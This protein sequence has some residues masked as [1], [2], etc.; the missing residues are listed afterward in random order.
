[1]DIQEKEEYIIEADA[2]SSVPG[3]KLKDDWLESLVYEYVANGGTIQHV[4]PGVISEN[5]DPPS[6]NYARLSRDRQTR[7]KRWDEEKVEIIRISSGVRARR[8][9]AD[10]S[11]ATPSS[12]GF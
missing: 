3:M 7:M 1:M 4:A 2:W 9:Y 5:D 8:S 12:S 11:A 6:F 10:S